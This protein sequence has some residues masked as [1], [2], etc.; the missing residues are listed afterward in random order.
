M[1]RRNIYIEEAEECVE[2]KKN[3]MQKKKRKKE[4]LV[5]LIIINYVYNNEIV[6]EKNSLFSFLGS[7]MHTKSS[8]DLWNY[9]LILASNILSM[10]LYSVYIY[11]NE[12]V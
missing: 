2:E 4:I 11:W 3:K 8:Y 7:T 1:Q 9:I 12:R 10:V 6:R 5:D